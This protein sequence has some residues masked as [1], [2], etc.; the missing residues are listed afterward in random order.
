MRNIRVVNGETVDIGQVGDVV[1]AY[2]EVGRRIGI[3][4]D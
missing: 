3:E 1:E 2:E 4:F